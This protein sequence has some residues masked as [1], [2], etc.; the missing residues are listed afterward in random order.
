MREGDARQHQWMILIAQGVPGVCELQ[1]GH[2]A[3]V[4]GDDFSD[5]RLLLTQQGEELPNPLLL[6]FVCI[7]DPRIALQNARVDAVIGE[8]AHIGVRHG[9]KDQR[10]QRP[11]RG[12]FENFFGFVPQL[13][14]FCFRSCW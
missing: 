8:L 14:R 4:P 7:H 5:G 12:G 9:L 6:T 13:R 1:L 2:C 11:R 10:G 3:D